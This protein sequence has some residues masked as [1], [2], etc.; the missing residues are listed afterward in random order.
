MRGGKKRGKIGDSKEGRD[1]TEKR[2]RKERGA[3]TGEREIWRE[4]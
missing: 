2:G 3:R 4:R 1:D